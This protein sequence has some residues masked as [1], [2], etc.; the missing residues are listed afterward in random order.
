MAFVEIEKKEDFTITFLCQE[1]AATIHIRGDLEQR[2]SKLGDFH[3]RKCPVLAATTAAA[4]GL[5]TES[6][7]S[8]IRCGVCRYW[9]M[10]ALNLVYCQR[11]NPG[12]AISFF[13]AQITSWHSRQRKCFQKFIR[14]LWMARRTCVE[15]MSSWLQ[16]HYKRKCVC[17]RWYGKELSG[18]KH[19]ECSKIFF[20]T[21][22]QS[23]PWWIMGLKLKHTS[24]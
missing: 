17:I 4:K 10:C 22:S 14:V 18:H 19:P 11:G 23:N 3:C 1:K 8:V 13:D 5:D 24:L 7:W 6:V 16:W 15:H 12:R 2:E 20:F 21:K 9:R